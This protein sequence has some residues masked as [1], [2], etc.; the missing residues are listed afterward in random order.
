MSN[1]VKSVDAVLKEITAP[2]KIR[3][4]YKNKCVLI[5]KLE[6]AKLPKNVHEAIMLAL[7]D[8]NVSTYDILKY[9]KENTPVEVIYDNI[10][11]H[12]RKLGCVGCT[13]GGPRQ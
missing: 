3:N 6:S 7:D 1:K 9:I 2:A 5:R 12:R 8:H 11:R 4:E 13:Y 10:L